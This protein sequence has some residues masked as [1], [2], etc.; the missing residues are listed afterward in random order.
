MLLKLIDNVFAEPSCKPRTISNVVVDAA[1]MLN[2][3][4]NNIHIHRLVMK[5]NQVVIKKN[6]FLLITHP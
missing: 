5:A 1:T 2:C 4:R 3:W 6:G